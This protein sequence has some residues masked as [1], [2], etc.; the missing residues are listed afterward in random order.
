[1]GDTEHTRVLTEEE[2]GRV[3]TKCRPL[4][5]RVA[6]SYIHDSDVAEDITDDSF[7]RM[8]EKRDEILTDNYEAYVFK[9]VVNRCLDYL[10]IQQARLRIQQDIHATGNR[11]QMYEINSL[12]SLNPDRIYADEI[13][14]II[15][16][17]LGKM[18]SLTRQVF[19][20]SRVEEKTYSE[21]SDSLGIPVRQVASHIQLALKS[22]RVSL[23]DYLPSVVI[24]LLLST[25]GI[26][27]AV[28]GKNWPDSAENAFKDLY[29]HTPPS[30][31][32]PRNS[33][34]A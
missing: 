17:S 23:K 32:K 33:I 21:I 30:K 34:A 27:S 6:N 31:S 20:A 8:W 9:A 16:E 22:L 18:P 14:G 5:I 1:M 12:K 11:M 7:I 15:K 19:L 25:H 13:M 24:T 29:G 4:F 10:K 28:G 26:L 2:F 3:F